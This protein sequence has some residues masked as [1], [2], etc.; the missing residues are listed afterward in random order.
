MEK[1]KCIDCGRVRFRK[2]P[3][4]RVTVSGNDGAALRAS[5]SDLLARS[6]DGDT[7]AALCPN[8]LLDRITAFGILECD[9]SWRVDREEPETQFRTFTVRI[10]EDE[11][12]PA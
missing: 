9:L 12:R 2:Q 7:E 11:T 4:V 5:I 3:K 6:N 8:C 1:A 10:E